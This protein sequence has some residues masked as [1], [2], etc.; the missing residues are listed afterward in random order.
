M[1]Q[2]TTDSQRLILEHFDMICSSP[3]D[4]YHFALPISPSLSWLH[5]YYSTEFSQEFRV[6]KGVSAGWGTCFRTVLPDSPPMVLKCWKDTIA[7]GLYSGSIIILNAI[8]GVQ[9]AILSGHIGWVGSLV[10][11]PDGTSLVSGSSDRTIK[12]WD[13]Q[14]G[15]VVK[16]F[17]GHTGQVS[18]VSMSADCTTIA[19]GSEDKTIR[20]W[21]TQTGECYHIITQ[22]DPVEYVCFFPLDPKHLISI[23]GHKIWQSDISGQQIA[24]MCD[25]KS[26]T[27]SLDGIQFVVC[28]GSVVEVKS[29]NSKEII[30]RFHIAREQFQCCC[31]SPDNRVIAVGTAETIYI[32]DIT[33]SDP[34]LLE[35]FAG[36]NGPIISLA[37]SSPTFLISA[38]LDKSVK[39]LQIGTSSADQVPANPKSAP[40]TSAPVRSITLQAKDGIA[41][42]SH[43][44]GV[45]RIWDILTGLCK[46]SF[47]SLAKNPHQMVTQLTDGRL[48]S[49]WYTDKKICIWD[50]EKG[51]LLR[52]VAVVGAPGNDDEEDGDEEDGDGDGRCEVKDLRISG[53]GS[54]VFCLDR[55]FIQSWSIGTGEVVGKVKFESPLVSTSPFLTID[56][57]RTWVYFP[58][59]E[60]TKGWDF[61]ILGSSPIEL[62][63]TSKNGPHLDFVGGIRREK[64]FLP[65][66]HDTVT[67]RVVFQLPGRLT[68]PSDVQWDGQYLV[69]GYD[70]GEVLILECKYREL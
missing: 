28:N 2:W 3:S 41:I 27:F 4:I 60:S 65:G 25:G 24:P 44:D 11:S 63:S 42:S 22:K 55:C 67:E 18:S 57:L 6:V 10:F 33:G 8:T 66:I 14:T 12:L 40:P 1:C 48:I 36:Q 59:V 61:G 26:T 47:Q 38:S 9:V 35:T 37:F 19:S 16:T 39:F 20:L 45:V 23:S 29:C 69:A 21:G 46:A 52:T 49:V 43:S 30:A 5:Q 50:T 17:L 7:V 64:S 62:S 53:D 58:F 34:H 68:R 51:E 32:W 70:S 54:T 31:F 13:M 15:G 56:G